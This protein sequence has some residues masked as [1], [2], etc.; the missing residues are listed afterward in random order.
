M[1]PVHSFYWM[2]VSCPLFLLDECVLSTVSIGRVCP[3]HCFYWMSLSRPLF[4]LD[5]CVLSTV[6]IGRVCPVHCFYWM[7]VSCPLFLL[8]ECVMSTVSSSVVLSHVALPR[9]ARVPVRVQRPSVSR[10]SLLFHFFAGRITVTGVE[11][12]PVRHSVQS[13]SRSGLV[14][15]R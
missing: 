4:L 14:G 15:V 3:V 1:C 2:S 5:E 10:C 9:V 6:S 13:A 8:D 7:S 12:I 11:N